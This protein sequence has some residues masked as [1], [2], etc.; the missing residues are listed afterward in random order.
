LVQRLFECKSVELFEGRF[1]DIARS[2]RRLSDLSNDKH[3]VLQL[4]LRK[5]ASDEVELDGDDWLQLATALCNVAS[6]QAGLDALELLLSGPASRIADEIG[7]GP[8]RLVQAVDQNEAE[9][10]ADVIWHLLGEED[11]YIRWTVARGL[12]TLVELGLNDDIILLLDRFDH[13]EVEALA[14]NDQ[15]LSFQNSQQWLLMGLAR[16]ASQHGQMLGGLR[17]KLLGLAKRSDLHVIDKL[18]IA[19]CLRHIINGNESDAELNALFEEVNQP[20]C[21]IVTSKTYPPNAKP[22]S[23]FHFEYDFAKSEISTV[24]HLFNLPQAIV[25]DAMAAEITH[26][27]PEA[28]SLDSFPGRDRYEWS[29]ENRYELYREHIQ[30]HALLN[31]ATSLSK[32]LPVVVRSY[33]A[34]GGS[35]WLEWRNRYD[36]TF[37]DGSWL[38]DRKDA[39][40][41]QAKEN[42]LGARIGQQET[43]LDLQTVMRKLGLVGTADALIPLYGHWSSPDNV[44]VSITSALT[45][46][47]GAIGRCMAF[48]RQPSHDLWL[49]EFWDQGYYD[50]RYRKNSPFAP[51]VWAPETN[52]LGIDLDDEIAAKGPAGRPRLGI[53]LTTSLEL[54]NE[55]NGGDWHAPDG[56]LALRSQVWGHWTPDSESRQ[57]R[58]RDDGEILWASPDW[59]A[60]TLATL[61]QRLVFTVTLWKY[62]SSRDYDASSGVKSVVV[63]LR[64]EDATLRLWQAKHA[65]KQDY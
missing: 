53:D 15:K 61:G 24:A 31:A 20:P 54:V 22:T 13:R 21:G 45:E 14:S 52:S 30:R 46:R 23:G 43:L 44:T 64:L 11:G 56:T 42:L 10:V 3:F 65:S 28:T 51:L 36:V 60:G 33:D 17:P 59:L 2:I 49:P 39:V 47:K 32:S 7:E 50:H 18:H 25:E 58:R 41:Q 55:S 34:D 5:V 4:V 19:R 48:A 27:W 38:S 26:R 16:A 62:R 40:P 35:P 37:D 1:R 8:F 9:F 6:D 63:G 12:N 57:H 29:R